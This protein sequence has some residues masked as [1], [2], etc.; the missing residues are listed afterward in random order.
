MNTITL[1]IAATPGNLMKLA[2]AFGESIDAVIG[3]EDVPVTQYQDKL[4]TPEGSETK[5]GEIRPEDPQPKDPAAEEAVA[6]APEPEMLEV[7]KTEVRQK[8][9]EL[10]KVGQTA[11]V[12][13]VFGRF[14]AKKFTQ[15][16]ES[17]YAEVLKAL[18]AVS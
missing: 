14:G 10:T 9:L 1:T 16:K 12:E 8:A 11:K 4:R 7:T 17:D 3:A 18:E 5:P 15:L 13:E 2:Q 6:Q